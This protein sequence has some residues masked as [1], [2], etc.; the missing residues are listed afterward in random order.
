[1]RRVIR[2]MPCERIRRVTIR[3]PTMMPLTLQLAG[4]PFGSVRG[5]SRVDLGGPAGRFL[6]IVITTATLVLRSDPGMVIAA[7]GDQDVAQSFRA[8]PVA[9]GVYER[10]AAP[11]GRLVDQ[12]FCSVAQ[13]LVLAPV[14]AQLGAQQRDCGHEIAAT[15]WRG[16]GQDPAGPVRGPGDHFAESCRSDGTRIGHFGRA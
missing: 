10:A 2:V 9:A 13:D 7:V 8:E 1:M 15:R 11:G 5:M 6:V 14:A 4:D 3:R 12:G 16:H